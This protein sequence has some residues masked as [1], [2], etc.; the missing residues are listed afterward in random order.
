MYSFRTATEEK[1]RAK[2]IQKAVIKK[3]I[4]HND[5]METIFQNKTKTVTTYSI[6]SHNHVLHSQ[7]KEKGFV[8]YILPDVTN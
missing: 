5:Y 4:C 6:Q 1:K 8:R 3:N 7:A 2:G